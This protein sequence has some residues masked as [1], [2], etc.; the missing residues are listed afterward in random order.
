V[1]VPLTECAPVAPGVDLYVRRWDADTRE[2]G[3]PFLLV[4]GLASNARTWDGVALRLHELGH[5]VASV[6]LRGHGSSAKPD[7][8]YDF[9]T[10]AAD[11]LAVLDHLGWSRAAVAGQSTGGNLALEAAATAPARVACVAG[12]DGGFIE[13]RARWPEWEDCAEAL[14]PPDL[15]GTPRA[16]LA[17]AMRVAHP[18]W[19]RDG[20]E[21]TL[22][23]LETLPDGTVR[24]WL[25]RAR[26]LRILRA[27]WEHAPSEIIRDVAVPVLF[28]PADSGDEWSRSKRAEVERVSAAGHDVRVDWFAPADHDVHVQH[29][30]R[31]AD[32]L[33]EWATG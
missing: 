32:L 28:V 9:A 4:H 29:P 23:N 27:L 30:S 24:A 15:A 33:H 13:L 12:V 31:V 16:R 17:A 3:V 18:D 22:A 26:H 7:D 10:L 8:G 1:Q 19:S 14:A 2:P 11:L 20:I 25:T 21:A 6:D 5:A